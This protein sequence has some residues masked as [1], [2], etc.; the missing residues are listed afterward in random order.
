MQNVLIIVRKK[1]SPPG[2]PQRSCHEGKLEEEEE[3]EEEKAVVWLCGSFFLL[4]RFP[5]GADAALEESREI[6]RTGRRRIDAEMSVIE[7][8]STEGNTERKK[9]CKMREELIRLRIMQMIMVP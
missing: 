5:G 2:I 7:S 3:E 6:W 1:L 4:D 8:V 9:M